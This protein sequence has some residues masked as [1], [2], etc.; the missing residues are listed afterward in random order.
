MVAT[1]IY[2]V[3]MV[4]WKETAFPLYRAVER[5]WKRNVVS[6]VSPMIVVIRLPISCVSSMAISCHYYYYYYY[7]YHHHHHH[8]YHYYN[9]RNTKEQGFP[10][11]FWSVHSEVTP[12]NCSHYRQLYAHGA[13][14]VAANTAWRLLLL[15]LLRYKVISICRCSLQSIRVSFVA[16][17][18][19]SDVNKHLIDCARRRRLRER[20]T[21]SLRG[22]ALSPVCDDVAGHL[23]PRQSAPRTLNYFHGHLPPVRVGAIN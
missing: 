4:L 5:R 7:Y 13:W 2:S 21:P 22:T 3:T 20:T 19:P 9:D 23:P 11:L 6:R 1:A 17:R 12:A 15:L 8:H 14:G 18:A 16:A 10:P